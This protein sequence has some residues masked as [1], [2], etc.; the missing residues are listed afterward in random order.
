MLQRLQRYR[1]LFNKEADLYSI[2]PL[3]RSYYSERLS[4]KDTGQ[5][6]AEHE[7]IVRY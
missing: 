7:S 2:H 6:K 3:I 5:I 1:L 4:E